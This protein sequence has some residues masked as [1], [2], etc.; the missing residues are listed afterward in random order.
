M[1]QSAGRLRFAVK[2]LKQ[3]RILG[4]TGSDG[5]EGDAAIDDGVARVIHDPHRA[6]AQ[7]SAKFV[8]A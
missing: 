5:L 1:L 2:A 6:A 3:A 4:E 7:L 8:F